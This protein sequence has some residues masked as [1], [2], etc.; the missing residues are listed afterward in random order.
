MERKWF[1]PEEANAL[2]PQL[3][4]EIE[5][6]QGIKHDFEEKYAHL[7]K[8]KAAGAVTLNGED[9]FFQLECEMEFLQI[10][11]RTLIQ[12]IHMKGAL[13]KDIERGLI[14]F[15][16][17]LHGEEVLLCWRHGEA[18]VS[19]YHGMDEGYSGR[20]PLDEQIS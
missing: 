5:V 2:L 14:D 8:W 16:A 4:R 1:T 11:A 12:S 19:H 20:K 13:L 10:E 18:E 17:L 6:L 15:P 3:G 7:R 9:P